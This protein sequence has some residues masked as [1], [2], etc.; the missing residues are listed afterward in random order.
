MTGPPS[1]VRSAR[2]DAPSVAGV[3]AG[4]AALLAYLL[5]LSPSI[6]AASHVSDSGELAAAAYVLGVA[7]PTGYPLYM[8]L[9]WAVSHLPLGEPAHTLNLFSAACGAL[10]AALVALLTDRLLATAPAT[11]VGEDSRPRRDLG[12]GWWAD[13]P[14]ACGGLAAG[15]FLAADPSFWLQ[16]TNTETRALAAAFVAAILLLLVTR[17]GGV[18]P[19]LLTGAW[20]IEGVAL[21]NHLLCLALL[22]ALLVA[23]ATAPLPGR[24]RGGRPRLSAACAFALLPGAALYLYL[25]V[26]AAASPPLDWG[27]PRTPLR[28]LWLITGA[29]YRP[30]MGLTPAAA[31]AALADR[32]T[33]LADHLGFLVVAAALAG[34]VL[35]SRRRPRAAL[36]LAL[37]FG[38]AVAQSAL[39]GAAAAPDYLIPAAA[40]VAAA[41]GVLIGSLLAACARR[42]LGA[43]P[44]VALIWRLAA[45][46]IILAGA[47][48][49]VREISWQSAVDAQAE[50]ATTRDTALATLRGLPRR[51]LLLT[52][53]DEDTFPLW[54]AQLALGV[55]PDVAV[56][57]TNL[58]A[59]QWYAG[60]VRARYPWLRWD[61]A[62]WPGAD[63][64][65]ALAGRDQRAVVREQALVRANLGRVALYWTLPD[66][67]LL[68]LGTTCVAQDQGLVYQCVPPA[69]RH[70]G[71]LPHT[72]SRP[73]VTRSSL[74]SSSPRTGRVVD[75]GR[76]MSQ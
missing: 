59:W 53:G 46:T 1:F 76:S 19:R 67:A 50:S 58:L 41:A 75:R 45:M 8:L 32:V 48:A 25:P 44:Q 42:A 34:A 2:P 73:R 18:S 37:T 7:H 29:Q 40:A 51:A 52:S 74:A 57:N 66:D 65:L 31:P 70:Q 71:A 38:A 4:S 9:G 43:R 36:L 23:T 26:R 5:T 10:A 22:P 60:G 72:G 35:L 62:P 55:R 49:L 54:Y 56:V 47:A 11:A 14:A 13:L 12:H 15:L 63:H 28:L 16:A 6:S 64:D 3:L 17:P 21:A 33:L 61:G 68:G 39:Y 20:A 27:D 24:W 30:L 69:R